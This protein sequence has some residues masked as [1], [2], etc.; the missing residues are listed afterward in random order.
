MYRC[1][2]SGWGSPIP[3]LLDAFIM[4]DSRIFL[5]DAFS[6][7]IELKVYFLHYV[8]VLHSLFSYFEQ[9]CIPGINPTWSWYIIL[10][11]CCWIQ[12]ASF[13]LRIFVSIFIRDNGLGFSF[14]FFLWFSLVLVVGQY[15]PHRMSYYLLVYATLCNELVLYWYYSL[16]FGR[17]HHW[18]HRALG[19]S[20]MGLLF[21]FSSLF[22][23][24]Y[25]DFVFT[26]QPFTIRPGHAITLFSSNSPAHQEPRCVCTWNV[27]CRGWETKILVI[28]EGS[29]AS[30]L[31]L[32]LLDQIYLSFF[33]KIFAVVHICVPE[34]EKGS[35]IGLPPPPALG[36]LGEWPFH[37]PFSSLLS[38]F[39]THMHTHPQCVIL[40]I[41]SGT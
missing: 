24:F 20:F 12:I 1:L 2:L 30:A 35:E 33:F 7:F 3:S 22:L 6:A 34:R 4:K 32:I 13:F 14:F 38:S 39:R 41:R 29:D 28:H 21:I 11:I 23:Q 16:I 40:D 27:S 19:F 15:Y 10:F 8:N 36:V 18:S 26:F 31:Y 25:S 37:N 9:I 17:I 5:S